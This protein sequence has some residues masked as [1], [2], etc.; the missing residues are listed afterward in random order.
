MAPDRSSPE[1]GN[2]CYCGNTLS[3]GSFDSK[4]SD[5]NVLCGGGSGTCGGSRTLSVFKKSTP[6]T[7]TTSVP[8]STPTTPTYMGCYSDSGSARTLSSYTLT[9]SNMT[10]SVC[11][12]VCFGRGYAF[13]GTGKAALDRSLE[14]TF[15]SLRMMQSTAMSVTAVTTCRAGLSTRRTPTVTQLA[16]VVVP[17]SAVRLTRSALYIHVHGSSLTYLQCFSFPCTRSP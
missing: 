5:C 13:A 1:Y 16:L 11:Q 9:A 14:C 8:A 4:D 6:T 17:P 15:F 10:N 2:E 3:G 7:T 12:S